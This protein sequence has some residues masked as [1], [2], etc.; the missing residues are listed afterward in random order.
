MHVYI[1]FPIFRF[2][3]R[4]TFS[5]QQYRDYIYFTPIEEVEGNVH[6]LANG[7]RQKGRNYIHLAPSSLAVIHEVA[8]NLG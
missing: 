5:G 3:N 4:T 1:E 7:G 6:G 2:V 8:H